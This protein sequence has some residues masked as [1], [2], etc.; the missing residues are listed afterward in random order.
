MLAEYF[1]RLDGPRRDTLLALLAPDFEFTTIWGER[2]FAR[3]FSGGVPELQAYFASR[4]ATGQRHHLV[5]GTRSGG[6]LE[7]AAGYTT[8]HGE[9]L[10]SFLV[11]IRL[12]PSGLIRRLMSART[13]TMHLLG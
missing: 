11:T 10:A 13:T 3:T 9:P 2:D 1:A 8:R 7:L 6:E 12:D 5:R 4:D